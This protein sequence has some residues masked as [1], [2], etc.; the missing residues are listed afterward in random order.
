MRKVVG[1]DTWQRANSVT[2]STCF[3]ILPGIVNPV[4]PPMKKTLS[5][6][7]QQ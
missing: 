7:E 6:F 4:R 1:A 2:M 3:G 5:S